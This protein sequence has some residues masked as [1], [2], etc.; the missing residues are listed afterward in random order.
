MARR[1]ACDGDDPPGV[2]RHNAHKLTRNRDA[3][4]FP[5]RSLS[6]IEAISSGRCTEAETKPTLPP[7][8]CTVQA[9]LSQ[10]ALFAAIPRG[11]LS[12]RPTGE[13]LREFFI[14]PAADFPF[15]LKPGD[16]SLLFR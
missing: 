14:C 7:A 15:F 9:P 4:R 8:R 5:E 12:F 13:I 6:Q 3:E 2:M 10:C 11:S 1:G 16:N